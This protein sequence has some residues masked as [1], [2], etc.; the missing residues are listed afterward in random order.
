MIFPGQHATPG[1]VEVEGRRFNVLLRTGGRIASV[2]LADFLESHEDGDPVMGPVRSASFL[3]SV[4]CTLAEVADGPIVAPA[5][6]VPA[7]L[8]DWA[9]FPTW[10]AFV[11]RCAGRSR[12]A[13]HRHDRKV[14]KLTAEV[15][16]VRFSLDEPDHRLLEDALIWKSRQLVRTR[17]LDR[18]ASARNR[19]LLHHLLASGHLKLAVLFAGDRALAMQ[20]GHADDKRHSSW[21]T[22]YDTDYSRYSPGVLLLEHLLRLSWE[23]HHRG[24]EFLIGDE[25]YKYNYATHARLI[26]PFGRPDRIQQVM[27]QARAWLTMREGGTPAQVRSAKVA[28]VLGERVLRAESAARPNPSVPY[29]DRLVRDQANW[30]GGRI[31]MP[32]ECQLIGLLEAGAAGLSPTSEALT[33]LKVAVR[34]G[35]QAFLRARAARE[36][37]GGSEGAV[38][39]PLSSA[40][41]EPASRERPPPKSVEGLG[42]LPGE[43]VRVRSADEVRATLEDGRSSGIY[44]IPAVMD[45][46]TGGTFVVERSVGRFYDEVSG[47]VVKARRAVL[48]KDSRCDGSQLNGHTCDRA[49]PVFWSEAWLERTSPE[50]LTGA[51]ASN[52]GSPKGPPGRSRPTA[53]YRPGD[54][55]RVRPVGSAPAGQVAWVQAAMAPFVGRTF[56]VSGRAQHAYDERRR[57]TFEVDGAVHL[58]GVQCP[59]APLTGGGRCDRGCTL[60]WRDAWLEAAS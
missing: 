38:R 35:R 14:G 28:R 10:E 44:Y 60:L 18:F 57:R 39:P 47:R 16:P 31:E 48:L 13:F 54:L 21:V 20:L 24:F 29:L 17:R 9:C 55:V 23:R 6:M 4:A 41:G 3:P 33:R 50:G 36:R 34:A 5:G 12:N 32:S 42:L 59:G 40:D 26:G 19:Q 43:R 15:G 51:P 27:R 8:V 46:F 49:C 37:P 2:P 45:R 52:E 22:A 1:T 7:P 30:P 53:P 56:R 25:D 11:K 58:D